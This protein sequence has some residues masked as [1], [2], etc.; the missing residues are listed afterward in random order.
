MQEQVFTH[1]QSLA[2]YGAVR[3]EIAVQLAKAAPYEDRLFGK[4]S[5]DLLQICP[6][7]RGKLSEELALQFVEDYPTTQWLLHANVQVDDD[8][9]VV[10]IA[11]WPKE[12][13]YFMQIAKLSKLMGAK[14][15]SAHAGRRNRASLEEMI[16]YSKE[17][18]EAMGLPVAVEGMYPTIGNGWLVDNWDEYYQLF[19]SGAYYALDLS[20]FNILVHQTG[21]V[22]RLL[23]K[24]MLRSERCLEVHISHND[25]IYDQHLTFEQYP[26]WYA[27]LDEV[28][29]NC[30]ILNECSLSARS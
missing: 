19:R 5:T 6:Q 16:A 22:P 25:G 13:D 28:H 9:R 3:Q 18:T 21:G 26:W 12:K 8:R 10:D 7:G 2:A 1:Y 14:H 24:A 11:D 4:A 17:M 20:H 29:P 30:V 27:Y 15:Y 23:L